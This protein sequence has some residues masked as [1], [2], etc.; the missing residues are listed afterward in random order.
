MRSPWTSRS[1]VGALVA[2]SAWL[3]A[4]S[5]PEFSSLF[6]DNPGGGAPSSGGTLSH[7]GTSSNGGASG[8]SSVGGFD[9]EAGSPSAGADS[10]EGGGGGGE[11]NCFPLKAG[12]AKALFV[13]S[14]GEDGPTCGSR[15]FP[16]RSVQVAIDRAAL[17]S[18]IERVYVATGVYAESLELRAGVTVEGGVSAFGA[19]GAFEWTLACS[20]ED[21]VVITGAEGAG[22]TV[23]AKDLF[24]EARLEKLTLKTPPA[25]PSESTFGV[26]A[27]GE[28]TKLVLTA[29]EVLPE[30]GGDGEDGA[31]GAEGESGGTA[32]EPGDAALGADGDG[33]PG[34]LTGE[35]DPELGFVPA[36]GA[37]GAPG[38]AGES[39]VAAANGSCVNCYTCTNLAVCLQ[40]AAPPSCGQ[41]GTSGCGGKGGGGGGKGGGGGSSVAL[42][43]VDSRVEVR[44]GALVAGDGGRGGKGGEGGP[45]GPGGEGETGES[46]PLCR[47]Q[48]CDLLL[49][50]SSGGQGSGSGSAG[51]QGGRGGY[52]GYGS[53]GSGGHSFAIVELGSAQVKLFDAP[54]VDHGKAG[55]GGCPAGEP[56]DSPGC[57][58]DGLSGERY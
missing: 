17:S 28:S 19:P 38:G 46:G 37:D 4:C 22:Q 10:G 5:G 1:I 45:P 27:L 35:F 48:P 54:R 44:G 56:S 12:D 52:G 55:R 36:D 7:G 23:L 41:P 11:L 39:G 6:Q 26:K 2:G 31:R 57:G 15:D 18:G 20:H 43:A 51:T 49:C 50:S 33:A 30:K 34:P 3:Y 25:G 58:A 42:F 13:T 21:R 9:G 40:A 53:G 14:E 24:G 29:V 47:A 16:C 32:C 8:S